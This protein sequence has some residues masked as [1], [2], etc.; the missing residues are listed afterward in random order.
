MRR[1]RLFSPQAGQLVEAWVNEPHLIAGEAIPDPHVYETM[2][3]NA[4]DPREAGEILAQL[5][6]DLVLLR[7]TFAVEA[8]AMKNRDA[9]LGSFYGLRALRRRAFPGSPIM[10]REPFEPM[11]PEEI[12]HVVQNIARVAF[13]LGRW[14]VLVTRPGDG[15]GEA[16]VALTVEDSGAAQGMAAYIRDIIRTLMKRASG[17]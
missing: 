14:Q 12:D 9:L 15:V 4:K 8:E 3:G 1:A 11:L 2:I 5:E 10:P 16:S 6:D 7:N 13:S 17:R